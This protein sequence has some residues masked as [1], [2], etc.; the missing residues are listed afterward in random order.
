MKVVFVEDDLRLADLTKGYLERNGFDVELV[1]DGL[2]GVDAILQL[3]PDIAILDL[4]LP[5]IDGMEICR[6]VRHQ[7]KG[8]ILFLTAQDDNIDEV[9]AL[10][11]GADDYVVK[12]V[13]PRVLL[14]RLRAVSRRVT[15]TASS[16]ELIFGSLRINESS[17]GVFID[18]SS[19]ELSSN[20]YDLLLLLAKNA[21]NTMDRDE[22]SENLRGISYDG[23]DRAIDITVSRLRKKAW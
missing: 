10:E 6:R 7:F 1:H 11:L 9:A 23:L 19:V 8:P 12:P 2:D 18:D 21:G 3:Q 14:A 13:E 22:I 17:R 4:N 15:M 5:G 16:N 20:E